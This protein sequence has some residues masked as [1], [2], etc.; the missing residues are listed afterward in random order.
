MVTTFFIILLDGIL[1]HDCE[2]GVCLMFSILFFNKNKIHYSILNIRATPEERRPANCTEMK[3]LD[4]FGI[5]DLRGRVGAF[6]N[7]EELGFLISSC[8]LFISEEYFELVWKELAA[9]RWLR[10][11]KRLTDKLCLRHCGI[12]SW[13]YTYKIWSSEQKI[14]TSRISSNTDHVFGRARQGGIDAW[15]FLVHTPDSRLLMSANDSVNITVRLYLQNCGYSE[16]SI[17]LAN[18]FYITMK[19]TDVES[20]KE[21]SV[22]IKLCSLS[23]KNGQ[24]IKQKASGLAILNRDDSAMFTLNVACASDMDHETDFLEAV[25]SIHID[26]MGISHN[27]HIMHPVS[28]DVDFYSSEKIWNSYHTVPGGAVL[29]KDRVG[30]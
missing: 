22:R 5:E 30:M 16:V 26:A 9:R 20:K 23:E 24:A 18:A 28:L 2:D 21:D 1:L 12:Y 6:L 19:T 25:R 29:L 14:P 7:S 10:N 15:I 17:D 13:K 3:I 11:R 8:H 27:K 4:V